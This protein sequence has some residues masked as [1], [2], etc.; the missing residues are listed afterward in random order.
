[1]SSAETVSHRA[2]EGR[3]RETGPQAVTLPAPRPVRDQELPEHVH[4]GVLIEAHREAR[5]NE[6]PQSLDGYAVIGFQAQAVFLHQL[7]AIGKVQWPPTGVHI[8]HRI[9]GTDGA[10]LYLFDEASDAL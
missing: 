3:G 9:S 5:P 8:H 10:C 2:G 1:M 6:I 7:P 4:V